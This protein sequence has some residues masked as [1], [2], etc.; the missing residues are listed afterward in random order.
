MRSSSIK[1]PLLKIS[2]T[3]ILIESLFVT[4]IPIL[5]YPLVIHYLY[6]SWFI[7]I[8]QMI[9]IV[10]VSPKLKI[11][12]I[13]SLSNY[14]IIYSKPR[15]GKL[16]DNF[17]V[18]YLCTNLLH[19]LNF[20]VRKY[21]SVIFHSNYEETK[22]GEPLNTLSCTSSLRLR[23]RSSRHKKRNCLRSL[24]TLRKHH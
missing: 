24:L 12:S 20:S 8:L 5:I 4:I 17:I 16:S 15:S 11:I 3:S 1:I 18:L 14:K 9:S 2:I 10:A 19:Y 22:Y 21:Y 6:F 23:H 7:F 13:Y